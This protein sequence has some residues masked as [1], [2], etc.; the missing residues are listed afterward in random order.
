MKST[1]K[2]TDTI[3]NYADDYVETCLA[4]DEKRKKL[5]EVYD[6]ID[7]LET[8]QNRLES[9]LANKMGVNQAVDAGAHNYTVVNLGT[10]VECYKKM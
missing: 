6:S 1:T 9:I 7:Q 4:L 10:R 2:F 5:K 3:T 8:E